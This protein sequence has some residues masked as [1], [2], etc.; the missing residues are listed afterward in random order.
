MMGNTFLRWVVVIIGT[1]GLIKTIYQFHKESTF[2]WI[3][4]II[5]RLWNR[6][7]QT[8]HRRNDIDDIRPIAEVRNSNAVNP[9]DIG[10]MV[11]FPSHTYDLEDYE[12]RFKFVRVGNTWRAY[13]ERM[14][15][16]RG[17][18]PN[19]HLTHRFWDNDNKTYVCWDSPI[20]R[21][22]DMQTIARVWADN[23]Q[24]Y[25]ANGTTF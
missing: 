4:P 11:Y 1:V 15:D 14:P 13:I 18:D 2:A 10:P 20:T 7:R 12:Y 23:L 24:S 3:V 17:R 6:V 9:N 21:L 5:R 19:G 22:S 16:L 8:H 25:I